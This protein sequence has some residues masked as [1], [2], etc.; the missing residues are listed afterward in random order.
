[1]LSKG[2][3]GVRQMC[4]ERAAGMREGWMAVGGRSRGERWRI[5]VGIDTGGE[6]GGGSLWG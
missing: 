4:T 1:M 2:P 3:A 6:G 5:I